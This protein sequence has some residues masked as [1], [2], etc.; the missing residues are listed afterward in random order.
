M[1]AQPQAPSHFANTSARYVSC[2]FF[3]SS[4][5]IQNDRLYPRNLRKDDGVVAAQ[6]PT[7]A[8][9]IKPKIAEPKA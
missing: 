9:P 8:K 7:V 1:Y 3:D 6:Q 2:A 4:F 5:C